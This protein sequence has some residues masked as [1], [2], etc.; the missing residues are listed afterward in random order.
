MLGGLLGDKVDVVDARQTETAILDLIEAA[1]DESELWLISPY[2]SFDKLSTIRRRIEDQC[3]DG[4]QIKVVIRDEREQIEGAVKAL[5][6]AMRSGL[7]L[8]AVKRLHAKIY[9]GSEFM[10]AGSAN[11]YDGS[12]DKSIEIG[13]IANEG[14]GI[15]AKVQEFIETKIMPNARRVDGKSASPRKASRATSPR[16]RGSTKQ[17]RCIRCSKAIPSNSK[18]PYCKEHYESWSKFKNRDYVDKVCHGCGTEFPATMAR[19]LC[20]PC[21]RS[22]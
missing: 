1:D 3:A 17:A 7:E 12:F 20:P 11:L 21:F 4:A 14:S 6:T 10:I 18:R 22:S 19:P 8:Y 9:L 15:Y 5:A 16:V 2:N 13:F